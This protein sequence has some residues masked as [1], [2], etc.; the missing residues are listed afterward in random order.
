MREG[1]Y[2]HYAIICY[3][4]ENKSYIDGQKITEHACGNHTSSTAPDVLHHRHA[5]GSGRHAIPF[6]KTVWHVDQTLPR[7]GDAI[8]PVLWKRCGFQTTCVAFLNF[9]FLAL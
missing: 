1:G 6:S 3:N 2:Y 7:A 4:S 9:Y 5:E 8:H